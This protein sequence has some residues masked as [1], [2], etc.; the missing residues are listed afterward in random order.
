MIA[1]KNLKKYYFKNKP[2]QINVIDGISLTF[3]DKGLVSII[4]PSGSGKS[5]L[6]NVIGGLDKASGKIEYEG[7]SFGKGSSVKK[8]KYRLNNIGYIFQ[9]YNLIPN[10]SIYD[11][12]K[13]ELELL[14]IFDQEEIDKRIDTSLE[15][16][17]MQKYIKKSV[18]ALSGG[19]QQ[20]VAI[21][22]ALIKG[23]NVILA[24][25]PTG[26]L[27]SKNT[28]EVMNIL[29][30]LS[31][32]CLIILVTHDESMAKYYSDR[33]I[34]IKDGKVISD[35]LNSNSSNLL[36]SSY[37][38]S[39]FLDEYN[40]DKFVS[41]KG[42]IELYSNGGKI[43]LK[44]VIEDNCIYIENNTDYLIKI[45]NQDSK[46]RFLET[47]PAVEVTDYSYL[48][49]L[50]F[51]NN[52][53]VKFKTR[54]KCFLNQVKMSFLN[55][56][57]AR[58]KTFISNLCFSVIGIALCLCL[59][60][61]SFSTSI[62][63]SIMVNNPIESVRV[64]TKNKDTSNSKFGDS[65]SN[66]DI[67][68]I[69][70]EEESI[71]SFA[72]VCSNPMFSFNFVGNRSAVV[73]MV[74]EYFTS[75]P[76]LYGLDGFVLED[77]EIIIS[78]P[79]ADLLINNFSNFG[80][81][82]YKNLKGLAIDL[83]M[84]Q[85]F[86]KK[87]VVKD[88]LDIDNTLFLLSDVLF[89]DNRTRPVETG[90]IYSYYDPDNRQYQN[91]E[92]NSE[93]NPQDLPQVL[94]SNKM[95]GGP[96]GGVFLRGTFESDEFEIVYLN[97]NDYDK[98]I[99][100]NQHHAIV[101]IPYRDE[102]NLNIIEGKKVETI[103]DVLLPHFLS[104]KF[105][106][107]SWFTSKLKVVGFYESEFLTTSR[108]AYML[109][110]A[111]YA[112]KISNT[113]LTNLSYYYFYSSDIEST[114][115]YFENCGYDA[116]YL[117]AQLES[118][119]LEEKMLTFRIALIV[120]S[121]VIIVMVV[122]IFFVNRSKMLNNIYSI[123]VNRALGAS[124]WHIYKKYIIDSSVLAVFT[125]CLGFIITY[126]FAY[127]ANEFLPGI[128]FSFGEFILGLV[129]I[130]ILMVFSSLLPIILL[131]RKTPIEIIGKYDI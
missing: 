73:S 14:N 36:D 21:A 107:G 96:I 114:I 66:G 89:Y 97:K 111:A 119:A 6:L 26:N 2:N 42:N 115:S 15:V 13:L 48:D 31:K 40:L 11:N 7:I 56:L 113:Q 1:L 52:H 49:C 69:L 30:V 35:Q 124:K 98:F 75:T 25:E 18:D 109:E 50:E 41:D 93:E 5:T 34:K 84:P 64:D 71:L 3:D 19:Q 90:A 106:I 23:C 128:C 47:R 59:C 39:L 61:I 68:D 22:R 121:C 57:F 72:N 62:D 110:E 79:I 130:Y 125:A 78:K 99:Y 44:L 24:D 120:S 10:M 38:D 28:I 29:K 123:G 20:R 58:K 16:V 51:K 129:V 46:K 95:V 9:N 45:N 55:L 108:Y 4:G 65:F 82:N 127:N 76:S 94:V 101:H 100:E 81:K 86:N 32:R 92:F 91:L 102:L 53:E 122:F 37:S 60:S 117:R 126:I 85:Y 54:I 116:V 105:P 33:I 17:G 88:V 87:I 43:D 112:E 118:E 70:K 83:Q 104:K 74:G 131:L 12:L 103:N 77:N 80:I 63:Q 8:D 27:D 67:V